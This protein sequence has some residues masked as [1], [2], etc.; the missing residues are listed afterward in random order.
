MYNSPYED[1]VSTVQSKMD[2]FKSHPVYTGILEH[3]TPEQGTAYLA[4]LRT[5]FKMSDETI[6]GFCAKN[7]SFG[8]PTRHT[9]GDIP[10][11]VSPTSL[12]YLYHASLIL[13]HAGS[14]QTSFVEVGCGYGGLFLA[15][16]YLAPSQIQQYH[17]VDLDGVL[18]LL[19]LTVGDDPRISFHSSSTFGEHVPNG[20]FFISNYCFSELNDTLRAFYRDSLLIRMPHGFLAWN[21]IPYSD[22]NI[23]HEAL[24]IPEKPMTGPGNAF[25]FF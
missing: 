12:R 17:M 4:L 24:V 22:A 14:E 11:P 13:Q 8:Y 2:P 16:S 1:Y 5:Q 6:L 19:R 25:V 20:C 10:T 3:V 15:L 9:I 23:G 21:F 7:D 18:R